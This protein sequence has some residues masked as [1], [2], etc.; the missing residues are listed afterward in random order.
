MK[1]SELQ[2]EIS[3]CCSFSLTMNE[4]FCRGKEDAFGSQALGPKRAAALKCHT[5]S[6]TCARY[7]FSGALV[8]FGRINVEE[9]VF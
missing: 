5:S 3:D 9:K 6:S 7:N 2:N 8:I 1:T 4:Y